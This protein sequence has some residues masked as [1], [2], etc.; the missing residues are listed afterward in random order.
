MHIYSNELEVVLIIITRVEEKLPLIL[1]T[2]A[3]SR[4][5]MSK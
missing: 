1:N 3:K 2:N 4:K 5:E